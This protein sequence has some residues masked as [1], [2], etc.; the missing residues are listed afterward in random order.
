[1]IA[2]RR[3]RGSEGDTP[4]RDARRV[5]IIKLGALGDFIQSLAAAR[6][7]RE[8]H[9]GARITLLTTPVFEAF[10]KA[11]PYFDIVETDGRERDPQAVAQM[12]QRLRGAKYDMV[13]DLQTSGRTSNYFQGLRPWPP[14]WSGVAPGCSHPHANPARETMHTLDRLADQLFEA[15]I[16]EAC[17]IGAAPLPDLSWVRMSQKDPPRVQPAY[18]GLKPPYGLIIPGASAHRPEKRW[19]AERYG[20]LATAI[21]KRGAMPAIIGHT[22]EKEAAAA[23]LRVEP[24]TKNLVSRTDFFALAAL[25]ERAAFSVGNDTG[26]MHIAAAAGSPCVVLF[27]SESDPDRVCPRGRGG[28]MAVTAESLAAMTVAQ[29]EQSIGNVGGFREL[30]SA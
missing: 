1:M 20:E 10:A 13:Y 27:S 17:E 4:A 5:L 22:D 8:Y 12:L 15:G 2:L 23:I 24:R 21:I 11:S 30:A 3:K 28:V 7:I 16:M 19:P 6:I 18:F 14:N 25:A 9:M 29:V 26:P